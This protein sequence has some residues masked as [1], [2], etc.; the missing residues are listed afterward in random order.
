MNL[1]RF[2]L[3]LSTLLVFGFIVEAHASGS[4]GYKRITY[5]QVVD[6]GSGLQFLMHLDTPSDAPE[7]CT[8]IN[9][10]FFDDPAI[11]K[12]MYAMALSAFLTGKRVHASV[13]GC[14]NVWGVTRL[15]GVN[16]SFEPE[17]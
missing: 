5:I 10:V 4:T 9:N 1:S 14:S 17:P 7:G 8:Q 16:L 6:G 12:E 3:S 2:C 11:V 15:H 13:I